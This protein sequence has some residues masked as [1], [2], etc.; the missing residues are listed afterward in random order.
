MLRTWPLVAVAAVSLGVLAGCGGNSKPSTRAPAETSSAAVP[1]HHTL[2]ISERSWSGG[3]TCSGGTC[4]STKRFSFGL[5]VPKLTRAQATKEAYQ[6][7]RQSSLLVRDVTCHSL[8]GA[9][10]R[11]SGESGWVCHYVGGLPKP[12]PG[13]S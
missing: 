8:G 13:G 6:L 5:N 9:H 3:Q 7:A 10:R 4:S 12:T 11:H 2:V 1:G